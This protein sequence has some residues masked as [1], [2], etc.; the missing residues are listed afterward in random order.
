[1]LTTM[2]R[3]KTKSEAADRHASGFM[4]R[5]PEV[6]R[7]QLRLLRPKTRRTMTEEIKMAIEKHLEA[8]G[9]WPPT[10]TRPGTST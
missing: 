5:L 7:E 3:K 4:V 10:T 1:M 6:Y 2:A 9:L 8:E